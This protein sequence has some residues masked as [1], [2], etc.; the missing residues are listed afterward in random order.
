MGSYLFIKRNDEMRHVFYTVAFMLVA[1][2]AMS[3]SLHTQNMDTITNLSAAKTGDNIRISWGSTIAESEGYWDVQA[4]RDGKDFKTLGLV[5]GSEPAQKGRYC[6]KE[7]ASKILSAF[8]L[9]RVVHIKQDYTALASEA[10][11][12]TK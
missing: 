6:F 12:L 10:I 7:K 8:T 2:T 11:R 3:Q 5:F 4:S 1:V 9:Y